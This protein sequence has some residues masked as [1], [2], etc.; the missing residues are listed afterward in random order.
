VD[1]Q[2]LPKLK[3]MYRAFVESL[4]KLK[5]DRDFLEAASVRAEIARSK[6]NN[7]LLSFEDWDIIENDL[8]TKQKTYLQSERDVIL[9]EAAWQQT[10]GKG[11]IP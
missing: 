5:V 6:Y 3:Q 8:I 9:A 7:G 1:R 4:E 2:T 11:I 10:R